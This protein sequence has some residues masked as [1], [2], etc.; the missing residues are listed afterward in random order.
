MVG[1]VVT[2]RR[3][4]APTQDRNGNDI[5][6]APVDTDVAGCAVAP[7]FAGDATEQGRQGVIVGMTIYFPS[8][9]DVR[10]TDLLVV[11]GNP[12]ADVSQASRIDGIVT[13]G[14]W[15]RR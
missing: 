5:P 9:T 4:G 15:R 10:A 2:V 13:R 8:G 3:P 7:R 11:R 14:A 6:G 12:L 1:E